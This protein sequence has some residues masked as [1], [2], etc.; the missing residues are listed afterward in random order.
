MPKRLECAHHQAGADQQDQRQS[1]L[2]DHQKSREESLSNCNPLRGSIYGVGTVRCAEKK[3]HSSGA[4]EN[5]VHDAAGPRRQHMTRA[6]Q[7]VK[8]YFDVIAA[9]PYLPIDPG[10]WIAVQFRQTLRRG[11]RHGSA[12]SVQ[13][14]TV[15][16]VERTTPRLLLPKSFT[17]PPL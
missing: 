15:S 2:N 4:A 14:F 8:T 10:I 13:Y 12:R 7:A 16:A 17:R 6:V 11:R 9:T 1:H 5:K 3:S